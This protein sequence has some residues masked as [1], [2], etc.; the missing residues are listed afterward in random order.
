VTIDRDTRDAAATRALIRLADLCGDAR[1]LRFGEADLIAASP[2]R[3]TLAELEE[4]GYI[5]Q[6]VFSSNPNP[7]TLTRDGWLESQRVSGRLESDEFHQRRGRLCA[8][9]KRAVDGRHREAILDCAELAQEAGLPEGWVW[10]ILEGQVLHSLDSLNR[11][12]VR[13]EDGLIY[14]PST[15][16]QEPI[17]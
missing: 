7:Y 9:M 11:Y 13:F 14:V 5:R 17:R 4:A 10:N 1:G 3:T 6:I 2:L 15:F 8:A 12:A 16:G